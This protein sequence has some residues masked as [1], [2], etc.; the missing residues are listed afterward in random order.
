MLD[1]PPEQTGFSKPEQDIVRG[2]AV[3]NQKKIGF[4]IPQFP[5]QTHIFFWREILELRAMGIDVTLFSTRLPPKGLISHDWSDLAIGETD[6]LAEISVLD[7]LLGILA[8]PWMQLIRALPRNG[9][10]LLRE[11]IFCAGPALRLR[12]KAR[13]QGI[14]HIHAHSCGR[15]A[16]IAALS[17]L[18]GGPK[19]S[20]TLHGPLSDYG[21]A[22]DFKWRHATAATIITKKLHAE[23]QRD[24]PDAL[25]D[26][27]R[28]QPMGVDVDRL[29]RKSPY[30]PPKKGRPLRL[31]SCG[32]LN[33]VKG[34]QDLIDAIALLNAERQ[35]AELFIAGQ[36]D[37]GGAGFYQTLAEHRAASSASDKIHLLGAISADAVQ[38]E[39]EQ[40]D[41]FVLASWH[42]PLGVA[43]MEAM[44]FAVP[45]I[46]TNSGGVPELI[47]D[48]ETGLLVPPKDPRALAN[49]IARLANDPDLALRLSR[50]G[51]D[52][53]EAKYHSKRGAETI[54][55]IAF[56]AD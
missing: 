19:Y 25:P 18:G 27:I 48:G 20:L 8:L 16:M 12:R 52:L 35:L 4:L 5:G 45:T 3:T 11:A 30:V 34:H 31:F 38:A 42:E 51:R 9:S 55:A 15:A 13:Q 28:L 22:Q 1:R 40:A 24:L 32:R 17:H 46:G 41:I 14:G 2:A 29:T 21:P 43:Y 10:A 49:A 39:L 6:Y 36:D 53:I 56:G 7:Y 50:N 47:T 26:V 44:S 33:I 37:D 54:A 23:M